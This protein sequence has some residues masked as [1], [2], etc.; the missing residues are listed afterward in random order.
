MR[1]TM[2]PHV[3][4]L[5]VAL[6]AVPFVGALAIRELWSRHHVTE[7][8]RGREQRAMA[9][10]QEAM[11]AMQD[12]IVTAETS[13]RSR[14]EFLERMS[15]ELRTP[16]NAVIGLSRQSK[17]ERGILSV[18]DE[19]TDVV[20]IA[21]RVVWNYRTPAAAK[22]L[23]IHAI[24]PESA[25]RIRLDARRFEQILENLVDNA[26]KS[27][28]SGAIRVTLVTDG[29]T[30]RPARLIV[31][32][33]GTGIPEEEIDRIFQPFEQVDASASRSHGGAGL[34]LPLARQLCEAIGC[35]LTVESVVGL[36][37]RFTIRFPIPD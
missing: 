36:G 35:R 33:T 4:D 19:D 1:P 31:S 13:Q 26:V 16:I 21:D 9:A 10:R 8:V 7:G 6:A 5:H 14:E 20:A 11:R 15:H 24:V 2:I 37:S 23:Y 22:G 12:A 29:A 34:G 18:A 17:I 25:P 32:D 30:C 27:T 28:V 3:N